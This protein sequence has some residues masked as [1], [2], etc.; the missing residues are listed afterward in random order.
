[1]R[2]NHKTESLA[3]GL[4]ILLF[5]L[6]HYSVAEDFPDFP[7]DRDAPCGN[8][9]TM[10]MMGSMGPMGPM[11]LR[12]DFGSLFMLDLTKEQKRKVNKLQ[13][14]LRSEHWETMGEIMSLQARL[15]DAY[16]L[17]KPDSKIIG[18]IYDQISQLRRAMLESKIDAMNSIRD[19][20]TD[21]QRKQFKS[22]MRREWGGMPMMQH[23]WRR[24][25]NH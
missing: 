15:R 21:G 1:M 9:G 19:V 11:G 13:D 17:D 14:E 18:K 6:T 24:G 8:M 2:K 23:R 4:F 3:L 10:G 20:L 12:M 7:I 25:M 22:G 5:T 16:D